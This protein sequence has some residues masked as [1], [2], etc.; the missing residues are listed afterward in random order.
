MAFI[1]YGRRVKLSFLG[2]Y[3]INLKGNDLPQT[4]GKRDVTSKDSQDWAE[5]RPTIKEKTISFSGLMP[6]GGPNDVA[7]VALETAYLNGTIGVCEYGTGTVGE[8]LW[9]GSG[10]ITAL[11]FK[12]AFDN[13]VEIDGVF[14]STGIQ[15]FS[16]T[17]APDTGDHILLESSG[18]LLMESTGYLLLQ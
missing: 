14:E 11:N 16:E 13:S 5:F 12:A 18:A 15:T 3:L 8:P 17:V 7:G 1:E 10:F 6:M 2:T 4:R 9:S